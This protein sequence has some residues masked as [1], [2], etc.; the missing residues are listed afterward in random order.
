MKQK[1]INGDEYDVV[2]RGRRYYKYLKR[3][4]VAARIKRDMRVRVR[5]EGKAQATR[6]E[7]K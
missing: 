5:R 7:D 6:W 2:G 4:G 3:A 1:L